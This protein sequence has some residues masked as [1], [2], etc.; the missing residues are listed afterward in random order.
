[1][2]PPPAALEQERLW[3]WIVSQAGVKISNSY[4]F[5]SNRSITSDQENDGDNCIEEHGFCSSFRGY[6]HRLGSPDVQYSA[7][8]NTER[9]LAINTGANEDRHS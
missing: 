2:Q 4:G 3:V 6:Y 7:I 8:E 5:L 9:R 1:M